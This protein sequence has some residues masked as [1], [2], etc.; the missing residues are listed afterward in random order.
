MSGFS[1]STSTGKVLMRPDGLWEAEGDGLDW[2]VEAGR[3]DTINITPTGPSVPRVMDVDDPLG[4]IFTL[5]MIARHRTFTTS[6]PELADQ[7]R[8]MYIQMTAVPEGATP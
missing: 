8:A 4:T 7:A 6:P 5:M 3:S 1:F 2:I